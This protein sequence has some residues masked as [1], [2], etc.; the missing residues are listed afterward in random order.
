[1]DAT[2][3]PARQGDCLL[4]LTG[5]TPTVRLRSVRPEGG[6]EAGPSTGVAAALRAAR[7]RPPPEAVLAFAL[8]RGE[9]Y[10]S[11]AMERRT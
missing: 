7:E 9:R 1:M 2:D 8:E 3:S 6:A 4:D 5:S 11:V 10:F